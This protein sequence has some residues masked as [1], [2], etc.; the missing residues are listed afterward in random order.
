MARFTKPRLAERDNPI[1][2]EGPTFYTRQSDRGSTQS[3]PSSPK[4]P[5]KGSSP[6]SKT[7]GRKASKDQ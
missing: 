5:D 7:K 1:F 3:T 4:T 6:G 2:S